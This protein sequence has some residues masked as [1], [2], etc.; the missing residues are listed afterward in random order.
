M[1]YVGLLNS[2]C[3]FFDDTY[4]A[5]CGGCCY[6]A[7]LISNWLDLLSI[8]YSLVLYDK[9][10]LDDTDE[11]EIRNNIITRNRS[12][13]P[14]GCNTVNHYALKV[15]EYFINAGDYHDNDSYRELIISGISSKDIYW[16]YKT[17]DWNSLYSPED[18]KL[19]SSLVRIFFRNYF[20]KNEKED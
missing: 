7:Y 8:P 12:C 5:N 16:M 18:N 11:N 2:W 15:G 3:Q 17:G 14:N 6:V 1:K 9:F 10:D 13:L 19:I 4:N 20:T